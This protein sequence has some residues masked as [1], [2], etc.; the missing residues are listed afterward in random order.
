LAVL[1]AALFA[2]S[3]RAVTIDENSVPTLGTSDFQFEDGSLEWSYFDT[4]FAAELRG[5]LVLKNASGSCAR[6]RLD[7]LYLG[8][9]VKTT[10]G[11]EACAS[12][13]DKH[14]WSVLIPTAP[15]ADIDNIKVSI[16]TKTGSHDWQILDSAYS[17]PQPPSDKVRLH[18]SQF[19]FGD[20]YWSWITSETGGSGTMYWNRKAGTTA[21]TP[22]LMGTL[23]ISGG[24]C[25]RMHLTYRDEHGGVLADKYGGPACPPD[26]DLHSFNI[27]LSPF[28]ATNIHSVTVNIQEQ[29]LHNGPYTDLGPSYAQ[30]VRIDY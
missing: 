7:S 25:A 28:T 14:K 16:E 30:T 10:Y 12:D 2:G 29:G 15:T 11:G 13:G 8:P 18:S 3:A 23:W 4:T 19:D 20:D 17:P 21:Y 1:T 24:T 27:D 26:L 5:T 6:M 22:R 9:I